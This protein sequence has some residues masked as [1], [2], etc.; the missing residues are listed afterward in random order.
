MTQVDVGAMEDGDKPA[1]EE[2]KKTMVAPGPGPQSS[3]HRKLSYQPPD[4]LLHF[5]KNLARTDDF[6]C[7]KFVSTSRVMG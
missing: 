1:G 3:Y 2:N 5:Q 4:A 6:E 7:V